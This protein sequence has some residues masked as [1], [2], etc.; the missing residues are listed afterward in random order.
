MPPFSALSFGTG[1]H[2]PLQTARVEGHQAGAAQKSPKVSVVIPTYD[3]AGIVI[4]AIQSVLTQTYQN[5]EIIVVDDGSRDNT[6]EVI[7]RLHDPRVRYIRHDAN[8]GGSAARNTGIEVAAGEYVAFLDSDDEWLPEK[9]EKQVRLLQGSD[10]SVGAVYTG[11]IVI[12]EHKEKAN[13]TIPKYRGAIL[14]ELFS[15]NR[16]GTASSVMVRRECFS[17]VGA[18]DSAM[19]SCQDW[20]MWIRL[21][22]YYKFDFVPES[23]VYY[24]LGDNG[25]ITKNW[26]AV[27]DGHLRIVEKYLKDVKRLPRRQRAKAFFTLGTYLVEAFGLHPHYPQLMRRGRQL[28]LAAFVARPLT[29]PYLVHYCAALNRTAYRVLIWAKLVWAIR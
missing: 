22:K 1:D 12:N 14:G 24:H 18:F 29:L 16:V 28:F 7:E 6:C 13:I 23:L 20:D 26:R 2:Y 5:L 17:R 15:A 19:V 4:R 25:R 8:Q 3:R 9:L 27:E 21:S 10:S 11:L